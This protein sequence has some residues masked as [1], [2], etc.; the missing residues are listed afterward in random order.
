M[1]R[2]R[3]L[4]ERP[5]F[6]VFAPILGVLFSVKLALV[7]L[8]GLILLDLYWGIKK[9]FSLKRI[10]C[11][12]FTIIFWKTVKSSGLRRSWRKA[13]EYGSGI[14]ITT[15]FQAAFFP[16]LQFKIAE[17][18]FDL[19]TTVVM[20]ACIIEVYSIFENINAIREE[21]RW[22]PLLEKIKFLIKEN[23]FR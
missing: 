1:E 6:L 9:T 15:F 7:F 20:L 22:K 19:I 14:L 21:N 4:L 16:D 11:N 10:K 17:L 2:L 3:I 8:A 13:T 18:E 5:E 23:F 12:P